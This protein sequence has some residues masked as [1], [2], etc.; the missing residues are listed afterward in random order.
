MTNDLRQSHREIA[1]RL[2]RAEGH[3]RR[4]V[5]MFEEQ[6]PCL[7]IAQ[8]MKAVEMAITNAKRT[9]VRNHL[10]ECLE[11]VIGHTQP[12]ARVPADALE[13]LLKY[14]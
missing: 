12:E 1:N 4:I 9:L 8:Q 7:D 6:R 13:D 11:R 3:V 2:K 10:D 5:T 14:L